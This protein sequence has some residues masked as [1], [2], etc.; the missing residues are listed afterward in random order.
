[1]TLHSTRVYLLHGLHT[2]SACGLDGA[3]VGIESCKARSAGGK[4]NC[5]D[6]PGTKS[7]S[8]P[9][10]AFYTR[11]MEP[12]DGPSRASSSTGYENIGDSETLRTSAPPS[13]PAWAPGMYSRLP[14][15]GL[16]ALLGV[17]LRMYNFCLSRTGYICP[18]PK[19]TSPSLN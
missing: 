9:D 16:G 17:F 15:L 3:E 8:T 19:L 18:L 2:A 4:C 6:D 12:D 13:R 10:S 11:M 14:Y 7:N 5:G 1:M